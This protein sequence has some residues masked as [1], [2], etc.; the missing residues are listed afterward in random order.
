[1]NKELLVQE[2]KI[3]LLKSIVSKDLSITDEEFDVIVEILVSIL[4]RES[5]CSQK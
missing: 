2:F 4:E 1:M 3:N 5:E